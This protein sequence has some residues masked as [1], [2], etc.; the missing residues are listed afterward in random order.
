MSSNADTIQA[1]EV[2]GL[3]ANFI[4]TIVMALTSLLMA[5]MTTVMAMKAWAVQRR[6]TQILH[7][8]KFATSA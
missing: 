4:F 1:L 5:W 6:Q 3:M 8:S 7:S 2:Y